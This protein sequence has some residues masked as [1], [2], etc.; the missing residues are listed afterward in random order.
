MNERYAGYTDDQQK[1]LEQVDEI[2]DTDLA[3]YR[4]YKNGIPQKDGTVINLTYAQIGKI[5]N[6]NATTVMRHVDRVKELK[7]EIVLSRHCLAQKLRE[8]M[9]PEDIAEQCFCNEK[10]VRRKLKKFNISNPQL[11]D[12]KG[13][14]KSPWD[15]IVI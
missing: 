13:R 5:Y 15:N 1:E 3:M 9:T 12:E 11:R 4:L 6:V 7:G 2:S 14:F 8:G 10:T